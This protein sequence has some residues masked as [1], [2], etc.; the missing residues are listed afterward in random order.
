MSNPKVAP[1]GS[2]PDPSPMLAEAAKALQQASDEYK[3]ASGALTLTER[4]M[5]MDLAKV[6]ECQSQVIAARKALCLA[7]TGEEWPGVLQ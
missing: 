3:R 5:E 2:K 6:R 7:A 1:I 4:Q